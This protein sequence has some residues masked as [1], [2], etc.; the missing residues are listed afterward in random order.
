MIRQSGKFDLNEDDFVSLLSLS[1]FELSSPNFMAILFQTGYLTFAE[2][3]FPE[4]WCK[5]RYPNREV[6]AS[7]EQLL[8]DAF[9][10]RQ[11]AGLPTVLQ[12]RQVLQHNDLPGM[13]AV[14]NTAFSSIPYD[15]WRSATELHYHALVH[16]MFNLL[17]NY[18][19]SEVHSARGRCDALVQTATHIY[20]FEFKL[21]KSANEA[22]QQIFEQNYLGPFQ[23]DARKKVAVGIN[24]S[25]VDRQVADFVLKEL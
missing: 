25:S 12:L 4:G 14:I 15:L 10:H 22:L 7:L 11:G 19:H 24:F 21:D 23:L 9:Q 17:G 16:L 3:N 1:N 20:A 8:L 18:L 13:V 5:L 2:L 6:K